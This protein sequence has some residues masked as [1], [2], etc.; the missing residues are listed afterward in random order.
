MM[1]W[2]EVNGVDCPV[3]PGLSPRGWRPKLAPCAAPDTPL[4]APEPGVGTYPNPRDRENLVVDEA[5]LHAAVARMRATYRAACEAAT[6][7]DERAEDD[8]RHMAVMAGR[9]VVG[10]DTPRSDDPNQGMFWRASAITA[11]AGWACLVGDP[12]VAFR[13]HAIP[14]PRAQ[15]P[16]EWVEWEEAARLWS[17][18][19]VEHER[20]REREELSRLRADLEAAGLLRASVEVVCQSHYPTPGSPCPAC[21]GTFPAPDSDD[22]TPEG[23]GVCGGR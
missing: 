5:T 9:R 3:A 10:L 15:W 18:R 2:I 11:A 7:L 21:G 6:P 14:I 1:R 19:A 4:G 20:E 23:C 22:T 17:A 16:E 12:N 8:A 13:A